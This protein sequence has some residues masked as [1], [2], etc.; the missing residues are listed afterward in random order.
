MKRVIILTLVVGTATLLSSCASRN[1]GSPNYT[2]GIPG[3]EPV[4]DLWPVRYVDTS[5]VY[6]TI[7]EPV[8]D[9]WD[10]HLL[11]ARCAVAVQGPLE[12]LTTYGVFTFSALTL[13][14]KST[15]TA[16]L[17][18]FKVTRANF[19]SD[20]DQTQT[21]R[22]Q[23]SLMQNFPKHA[24]A[25]ALERLTGSLS[26]APP[27]KADELNNTPPKIIVATRPAVLVWIDGPPTWRAVTG[28]DLQRVINT[29]MLVLKDGTG[30]CYLR[31][32]D[33]YLQAAALDG[34]WT[35]A[36]QPPA[37]AAAAEKQAVDSGA[38]DLMAGTPDAVRHK[39][40]SLH[41][42]PVPDVFVVTQPSELIQFR[43]EVQ[44]AAIPGT[45]LL[46]AV[47][48]SGSVFKSLKNQ[49]NYILISGRWYQA[50]SLDGPWRFVPGSHLP[51]DFAN[52]PDNSPK[53][54][55]KASV[56]GTQQATEALIANSIPQSIAVAR[57]N[58]LAAPQ[59]DGAMQLAPIAGT[60][61][62]YIV[63]SATPIIEV[64]PQTWYACQ[65]GVWYTSSA[66]TGP[67]AVATVVPPAIYTIHPSSPLHYLT[68][69][70]VYGANPDVVYE[71]YTPGYM[72]TEV[73]DDGTVVYGTGYD[74][75]PWIG[76]V[77]YGPPVTWGWGFDDCWTPWWGWGF[78]CGFGWGWGW[79][80]GWGGCF[81]PYPFWGGFGRWHD[82]GWWRGDRGSWAHTSADI[83]HHSGRF[84]AGGVGASGR[85]DNLNSFGQAYN[86]RTGR[87]QSGQQARVQNVSGAAWEGGR[88]FASPSYGGWNRG[89]QGYPI[90]NW[91]GGRNWGAAPHG[92]WGGGDRGGGHG[93]GGGGWG[94][95]GGGHGG[96]GGGGHGR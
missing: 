89:Y 64:D 67:W 84:T 70:Q 82:H 40:P 43:G 51:R 39:M 32:F 9:S 20:P 8:C 3:N 28:T 55:V 80:W 52:I 53:E 63:N 27:P 74:Y 86:S 24:P 4:V 93:G 92:G 94:G 66:A 58:R 41:Q 45:E 23:A 85:P 21:Q 77:W 83:Y 1:H 61:L 72:G 81:P 69:V 47:N 42:P 29:R 11:T 91:Y 79:G 48:T 35:V 36:G 68:Y 13:V 6:F 26:V 96:G 12:P 30:K 49:Q 37:G 5:G 19:P 10:G 75:N 78:D 60:S 18:D 38:V 14:D 76:A 65:A 22:Y 50:P 34:P 2:S 59:F 31:L 15:H 88:N 33:G 62:H 17:A 7:F 56:P 95:G 87:L 25:L 54:N 57:T 73:A 16:T 44:Y 90:G 71:G 46:Y